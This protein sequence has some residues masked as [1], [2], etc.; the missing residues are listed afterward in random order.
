MHLRAIRRA[1]DDDGLVRIEAVHLGQQLV[2]RLLALLVRPHRALHARA[3]QRVELVDEDDAGRLRLRLREQVPHARGADADEH[4]DELGPAQA[5]EGHLRFAR[6]G[7]RQQRLARS[8]RADQQDP[9]RDVSAERRVFL[10]VL[11]EL[12][13]LLE[14][15]LGLVHAGDV[16]EAHFHI[17]FGEDAMLAAR[18][19][20]DAAFGAAHA[21]EEE[22]PDGKQQ[23]QRDDPAEDFRKPAADRLAGVLHARRLEVLDQLRIFDARCGEIAPPVGVA[24]VRPADRLVS[25]EPL[26][27]LA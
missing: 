18:K 3:S 21:S 11:E 24:L 23:Q 16:G 6:H 13:N 19:R 22:A 15:L 9:F 27:D 12:D 10:R 14:F 2:E 8:R 25:D 4:L 20:H 7:A 5:E 17:V 1:P 26:G